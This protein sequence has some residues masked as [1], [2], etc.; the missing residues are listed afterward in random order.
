MP[1]EPEAGVLEVVVPDGLGPNDEFTVSTPNGELF[2][3]TVPDGVHGGATIVVETPWAGDF[4]HEAARDSTG[5]EPAPDSTGAETELFEVTVPEGVYA[6]DVLAITAAWGGVFEVVVP[7]GFIPGMSMQVELP[8]EPAECTVHPVVTSEESPGP[9]RQLVVQEHL[10]PI[11]QAPSQLRYGGVVCMTPPVSR[12]AHE[13]AAS[14]FEAIDESRSAAPSPIRAGRGGAVTPSRS[15]FGTDQMGMQ[16]QYFYAANNG[17]H[18]GRSMRQN[19]LRTCRA[20]ELRFPEPEQ[21]FAFYVGQKVQIHRTAGVWSGATVLEALDGFNNYYKCRL[22][23]GSLEKNVEED[24]VREPIPDEGFSFYVGQPVEIRLAKGDVWEPATVSST[25][26]GMRSDS[27]AMYKCALLRK[28]NVIETAPQDR[29][30]V[31][32]PQPG[33][34]F[35]PNQLVQ[36]LQPGGTWALARIIDVTVGSVP[37]YECK[38]V[39]P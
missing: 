14:T 31:P 16:Q 20:H 13:I 6:G 15:R 19:S 37:I 38:L 10:H 11:H 9:R 18:A 36:M 2:S 33:C 34:D 21:G 8:R 29:L 25:F 3:V 4:A 5:S 39:I 30:R 24:F 35:Y 23:E 22:G 12:I 17:V 28:E 26:R 7:D 1:I 32:R 27:E